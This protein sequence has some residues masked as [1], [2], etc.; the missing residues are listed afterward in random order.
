MAILAMTDQDTGQ[1]KAYYLSEGDRA[2]SEEVS[3]V[4]KLIVARATDTELEELFIAVAMRTGKEYLTAYKTFRRAEMIH[5]KFHTDATRRSQERSEDDLEKVRR[6]IL[7]D[8]TQLYVNIR[9]KAFLEMLEKRAD[10][11][12]EIYD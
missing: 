8:K 5:E 2:S 6:M 11:E 1:P 3:K 10:D 12:L 4:C 7:S 9:K